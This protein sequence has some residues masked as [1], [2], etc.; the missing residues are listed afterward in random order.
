MSVHVEGLAAKYTQVSAVID[1]ELDDDS[2]IEPDAKFQLVLSAD[3][4]VVIGANT[5][6]ELRRVIN[7]ANTEIDAM[8]KRAAK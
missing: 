4:A 1:H 2:I 5:I 7:D 8:E 3:D 6:D